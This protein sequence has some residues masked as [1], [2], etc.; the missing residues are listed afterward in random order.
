MFKKTMTTKDKGTFVHCSW[1]SG[2]SSNQTGYTT[3]TTV[4][5]SFP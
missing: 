1:S 4:I 2:C 5:Q 3:V